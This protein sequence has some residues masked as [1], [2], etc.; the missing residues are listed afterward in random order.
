[1]KINNLIY[2]LLFALV[3]FITGCEDDDSLFSG[4]ENYITSFRLIEGEHVYAGCIVGDSLVLSIPESVSLE[5]VEVEFTASENAT[6]DPDPSTISNWEENRTFTVISYNRSQRIYKYMVVRTLVAQAGDVVLTTP[7]EV[8]D[9]ASRGINKIEGN[10][11]IG[12]FTGTVK[13]DTLTSIASLSSLKE[14]TGKVTINPTYGG[15]SLDGLQNLEKVG[16]FMMVTRSTQ[17][18][19]AGIQNLREIDLSH[20]KKV[21]S[22]LIISA[23]TLY[24]LNSS[25]LESV[26]NNLQF[27]VW[28]V[29]NMDFGALKIVAGNLSFP[30][31]HYYGGGNTYLPEQV[32]FP[33][34]E[35]I[36]NQLELKNPHRIKELLFPALISATTVSLEQTDV[37][38]KIDFSQLREVVETLTLQWTH[39]VKEYDFSQLQSVGGLRVYYI[40]DLEKINL[41]RLSRVGTGGFTID[42]CNKLNDLDLAALTEVQGNFVLAAPADLNALKEVGG[43][44]TFSANA[45]S[46]DGLN[47]LTSVGGNFALSGTAKEMN[48]FKALTTIKGSMTLNNMNN[49]T[50]VNG[51]DVLTS[52]GSGLS[53]SNMGKVEKILFLANLQGA[54]FAQCSFSQLPA[55]QG[56]DV[57][58]FSTSKLTIND[59]G[60]DF[61]LRGNS[62]L[63]GE[64]TLSSSRGIRFDGIEK[65][66]TLSVTGFT[67][68]DPAVFNFA[69]L[70][71]VDKLTVNLGYVTENAAALCFPDLEEVTG[72]LTLSEGSN[73]SFKQIEPVQL[74]VLRKVGALTYTGVIPVLELPAL[75]SVEG[76]FRVST[77]YQNGPVR[78]LEEICVPNLKKV[79]GLVLTTSAYNT[80]SYNNLITDLSCFSALESAGYVNIQ[81][82]AAL[83]SFEGL[84]KV[85]NKLEGEDSWTV[86]ENA[87]NPTFEQVKAGELV[88]QE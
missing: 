6:L 10:L 62:E 2:V 23:D 33:H 15:V 22:D 1:M 57:S 17:Y 58:G 44:F 50:C 69:G 43:N 49:V 81:K 80:N 37:L 45:E 84:K 26:G 72:L 5:N 68:K 86:S 13:E 74:P 71:Q 8:E 60:A 85:I 66:Q 28:D 56:L 18:G 87:Y 21:G 42:V 65:V 4:D 55:L 76:E 83:V 40:A 7:E 12:K 88:K 46:F 24:S 38:E 75:E 41:H 9:F 48:G 3:C 31:R 36:G 20:L 67:Q 63:N 34:L 11:V 35:T 30:G 29:K 64:V 77:S 47:S 19:N 52:I 25:A 16:E 59:V 61:V 78:M 79:G 54:Q 27:E 51:F 32:E 73:G 70:K 82:Q 53:I 14:V 39:R